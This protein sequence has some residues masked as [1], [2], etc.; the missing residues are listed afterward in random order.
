MTSNTFVEII[1]FK[2]NLYTGKQI[3]LYAYYYRYFELGLLN[4]T[5]T[6]QNFVSTLI[7]RCSWWYELIQI[8]LLLQASQNQKFLYTSRN[9][10]F[11][12]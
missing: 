9:L 10:N 7:N 8:S 5:N 4:S 3:L 12:G 6:L 2:R 1:D 11:K